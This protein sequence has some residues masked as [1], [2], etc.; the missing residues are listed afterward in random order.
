[1][2]SD[3]LINLCWV[4]RLVKTARMVKRELWLMVAAHAGTGAVKS[5]PAMRTRCNN[6]ISLFRYRM[7]SRAMEKAM[8]MMI[9][10]SKISM[11]RLVA[12]SEI[13]S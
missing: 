2:V 3:T 9:T 12:W 13:F 10:H 6:P 5:D 1:M 8:R 4:R 7:N 11:R